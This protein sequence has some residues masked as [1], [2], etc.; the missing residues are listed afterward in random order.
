MS[1]IRTPRQLGAIVR[2]RRLEIG[3][4]QGE[5]AR[6]AGVSRD[7]LSTFEKGKPTVEFSHVLRLLEVLDLQ[8]EVSAGGPSRRGPAPATV[9]LDALLNSYR[10]P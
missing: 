4:T 8:L 9:D 5:L 2:G 7:W 3:L 10:V 1:R 6:R